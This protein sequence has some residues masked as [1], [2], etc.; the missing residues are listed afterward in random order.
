MFVNRIR[1]MLGHW[2]AE[3]EGL[4]F[5]SSWGLRIFFFVPH[6]YMTTEDKK[7]LSLFL[8]GVQKIKNL[9]SLLFYL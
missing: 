8:Y 6:S 3:S 4:R 2:N 9:P 7:Q 5:D 1:E